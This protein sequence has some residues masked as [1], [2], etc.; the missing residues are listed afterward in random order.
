VKIFPTQYP[1]IPV[2]PAK[3]QIP[4]CIRDEAKSPHPRMGHLYVIPIDGRIFFI[5][6]IAIASF[7]KW[8]SSLPISGKI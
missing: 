8:V 2:C 3:A 4:F 7:I 1:L 5:R 6:G